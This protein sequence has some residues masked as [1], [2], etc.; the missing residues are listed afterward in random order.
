MGA[1]SQSWLG[2]PAEWHQSSRNASALRSRCSAAAAHRQNKG[3]PWRRLWRRIIADSFQ[4]PLRFPTEPESAA[5]GAALQ[6][7]AVHHGEPV[8]DFV[9]SHQPPLSDDVRPKLAQAVLAHILP[10]TCMPAAPEQLQAEALCA[11]EHLTGACNAEA[12]THQQ[13]CVSV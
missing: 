3:A 1:A 2:V 7:A 8:A 11:A 6:A 12:R 9:H 13:E 5:L 10:C 4:L